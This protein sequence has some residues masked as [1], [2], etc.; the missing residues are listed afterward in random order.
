MSPIAIKSPLIPKPD[1]ENLDLPRILCL[2]GGGTNSTIF[3]AQ[4]RVLIAQLKSHFR[5]V[6]ADAPFPSEPGPDVVSVYR[7]FG[8]FKRWLRSKPEHPLMDPK[9]AVAEIDR[10]LYAA[11]Q[12]DNAIG[13]T[14]EW[15]G[16][17]GFSQGAKVAASVL[18]RQQVRTQLRGPSSGSSAAK[19][20][21]GVHFR[22]AVLMAGQGP[23]VSFDPELR[24]NEAL[25]SASDIA[26]LG[27]P[28]AACLAREEHV[29]RLPTIHVHGTLD[30]GIERHRLL[31]ETY[32]CPK[33][34]RLVQ[35]EGAH[36]VPIKTRDVAALVYE[37]LE[38]ARLTGVRVVV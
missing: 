34:R 7:D 31:L 18:F 16:I 27:A 12:D 15:V 25:V 38:V 11:M 1:R 3:R 29:L 20:A 28:S 19:G 26:P 17:L 35:W 37:I 24:M 5:L 33:A 9:S 13:G 32:C 36:R 30:P 14:G 10:S 23:I 22:F 2:H 8:P 21:A 4:C 6:F